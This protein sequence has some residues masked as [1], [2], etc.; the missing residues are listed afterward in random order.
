MRRLARIMPEL[1]ARKKDRQAYGQQN[2]VAAP[3]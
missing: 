2:L 1:F 3:L